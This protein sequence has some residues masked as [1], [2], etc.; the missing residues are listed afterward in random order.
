MS[1]TITASGFP[2]ERGGGTG[3]SG[4]TL[5]P[6]PG[7]YW[8]LHDFSLSTGIPTVSVV[9]ED[10]VA[11]E[12]ADPADNGTF[13]FE[14]SGPGQNRT[15]EASYTLSGSATNGQDYQQLDGKVIF[16]PGQTSKLVDVVAL[17]DDLV[18]PDETVQVAVQPGP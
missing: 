12:G 7:S 8:T 5:P 2:A 9:A 6:E 1:I 10:A 11:T 18:E 3:G 15:L 17:E 4:T 13:R 16:S 14:R